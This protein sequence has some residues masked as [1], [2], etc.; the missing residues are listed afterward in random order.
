MSNESLKRELR[1]YE[2]IESRL[3]AINSELRSEIRTIENGVSNAKYE[4]DSYRD[5]VTSNLQRCDKIINSSDKNVGE[6]LIIQE[7]INIL[8]NRYKQMESAYKTIRELDEKRFSEYGEF[9]AAR[10]LMSGL[11]TNLEKEVVGNDKMTKLVEK[12]YYQTQD[13]WLS[14]VMISLSSA[15]NGDKK[16]SERALEHA[17]ELDKRNTIIFY[18]LHSLNTQQEN[19]ALKWLEEYKS[20]PQKGKESKVFLLFFSIMADRAENVSPK[21]KKT[22]KTFVEKSLSKSVNSFDNRKLMM[23]VIREGYDALLTQ[24]DKCEEFNLLKQY[25]VNFNILKK[26]MDFACNSENI[27]ASI[28]ESLKKSKYTRKA[29]IEKQMADVI[30][31]PCEKEKEIFDKVELQEEIIRQRGDVDTARK[32]YKAETK[33]KSEDINLGKQIQDWLKNLND[34]DISDDVRLMLY[35]YLLPLN[36]KV[37][38]KIE[39]EYKDIRLNNVDVK[40][41]DYS[42]KV[43]I[44][45]SGRTEQDIER[46]YLDKAQKDKARVKQWPAYLCFGL[47]VAIFVAAFFLSYYMMIASAVGVVAGVAI[48][49]YCVLKRKSI[50]KYYA[51]RIPQIKNILRQVLA[52]Y[53]LYLTQFRSYQKVFDSI[54]NVI[55]RASEYDGIYENMSEEI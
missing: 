45:D 28:A 8:Y 16:A 46:F 18:F 47:S 21:I 30:D 22:I 50:D 38:D 7:E 14:S 41:E 40:I 11:L 52:E 29:L 42:A 55:D 2:S 12:Q 34:K 32:I 31:A 26:N 36:Q 10:N 37:V 20:L 5:K 17:L 43:D 39:R 3:Q 49:V 44:K 24:T 19:E 4:L 9:N 48:I 33:K 54:R 15:K 6:A 53:N 51:R 27:L 23:R 25:C 35:K 13:Y 1:E